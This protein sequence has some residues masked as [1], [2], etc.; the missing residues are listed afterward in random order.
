MRKKQPTDKDV[1]DLMRVL[2]GLQVFEAENLAHLRGVKFR[3]LK[4]DGIAN[5]T[6]RDFNRFRVSVVLEG[7]V[8]VSVDRG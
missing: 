1:E 4:T 8:V 2:V 5:V 3:V 6:T 7:G